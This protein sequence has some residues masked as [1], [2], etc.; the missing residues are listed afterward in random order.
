M[1][2]TSGWKSGRTLYSLIMPRTYAMQGLVIGLG[3]LLPPLAVVP[4]YLQERLIDEAIPRADVAHLATLAALYA[5][6]CLAM[7]GI[8]FAV[9]YLRGWIAEVV[10][11]VLRAEMVQAQRRREPRHARRALGTVTSV[12]TAEVEPLG[13]FAAEAINTPLIQ[14]GTLLGVIGYMSLTEPRL[15]AIGI[16]ALIAEALITPL[17]QHRINLLTHERIGT[18]RHAGREM[19]GATDPQHADG[20]VAGLHD[21]RHTYRLRLRMNVLKAA[22]KVLNNLIGHAADIAIIALGGWMVIQGDIGVGV[23]VAFLS[24]LAQVRGPW[25]ELIGFYRRYADTRVKYRLV[26]AALDGERPAA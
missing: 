18:L 23:I 5:A 15:A 25:H 20:I 10:A 2:R 9:T 3:L 26:V 7:G 1:R 11:R 19:I 12:I 16:A 24:G 4:L 17:I 21:V 13:G 14:G 22:L 8:K 6:A